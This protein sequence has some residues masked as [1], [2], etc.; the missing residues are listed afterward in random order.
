MTGANSL[1]KVPLSNGEAKLTAT[2]LKTGA[3]T[4]TATYSGDH[5]YN[6]AVASASVVVAAKRKTKMNLSSTQAAPPLA[7]SAR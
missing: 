4:I 1:G 2:G 3:N 7:R 6:V 5:H